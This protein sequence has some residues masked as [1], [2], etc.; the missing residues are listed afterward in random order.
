M[1][2]EGNH[3]SD[4]GFDSEVAVLPS[5]LAEYGACIW[6]EMS[7]R[8]VPPTPQ[9]YA[10][11]FTYR[12]GS[13]S[14]LT[15]RVNEVLER[16]S[17]LT[18]ELFRGL[19]AEFLQAS[20]SDDQ[21][22]AVGDGTSEIGD[23]TET[24][25]RQIA[26]GRE[27]ATEYGAALAHWSKRLNAEP[28]VGALVAAV[29]AL[30][31]ETTRAAER[32]RELEQKLSVS[33]GR[34]NQLRQSL[35]EVKHEATTYPLT[36]I[37]NRRAFDARLR[38]AVSRSR[39]DPVSVTSLLLLDVDH[40]KRFNDTYGHKTGDLV[41]RLVAR[42]L[43]DSVKGRDFVA[44][45][46]GEEFAILFDGADLAAANVVGQQICK[47]VSGKRLA[48]KSAQATPGQVTI[49][50]GAAQIRAGESATSS[51]ARADSAL[52]R[53]KGQGRNQ[54]CMDGELAAVKAMSW[55]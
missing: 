11:W 42:L 33:A 23:I 31:A 14:A 12:L 49:S 25:M 53:A 9:A 34:I 17:G 41:L 29:S 10:V 8:D 20:G 44:R 35:N 27:A 36:G 2:P 16:R 50:A 32:N 54:T 7:S 48:Q 46:G 26:S 47:L 5:R 6:A 18:A 15:S 30:T 13:N 22:L 1:L 43:S 21:L 38:R 4:A 19:H 28:N 55:A 40:F 3:R 37:G 52:Y 24:L 51:V 39:A 45:Y